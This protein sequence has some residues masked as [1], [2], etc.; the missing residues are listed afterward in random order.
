MKLKTISIF[1]ISLFKGFIQSFLLPFLGPYLYH[2]ETPRLGV[3]LDIQLL[4][5]TTAT[6]TWDLSRVCELHHSS[7]QLQTLNPLSKARDQTRVLMDSSWVLY[8]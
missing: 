3:E 4:A 2:M 1:T 8:L 6:A 7:W 5:Y